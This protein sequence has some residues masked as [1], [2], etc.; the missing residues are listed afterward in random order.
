MNKLP[1]HPDKS[2]PAFTEGPVVLLIVVVAVPL[3]PFASVTVT[4][5]LDNYL[6]PI[7]SDFVYVDIFKSPDEEM[8]DSYTITMQPDWDYLHFK[9]EFKEPGT[10]FIDI[11]NAQDIFINTGTVIIE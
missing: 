5:Y 1:I 4:I 10:Y 11:F 6:K 2:A 7:L 8:W 3:H 9:Y